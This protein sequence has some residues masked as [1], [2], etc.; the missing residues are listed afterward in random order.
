MSSRLVVAEAG[1]LSVR[2]PLVRS[3]IYQAATAEALRRVHVALAEALAEFGDTDRQVWHL[4][5]AADGPD[6][7]GRRRARVRVAAA[8]RGA[9]PSALAAYERAAALSTSP[10]SRRP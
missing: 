8:R 2:H 4:A 6:A 9:Y 5:A 7:A 3:A 10:G 1:S